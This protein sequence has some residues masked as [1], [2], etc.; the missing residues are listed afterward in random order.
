MVWTVHDEQAF[1]RKLVSMRRKVANE[2]WRQ[3]ET[4][5][6]SG[7]SLREIARN[8]NIPDGTVLSRA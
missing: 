3:I 7:I 5:Y 4:A 6:A 8:M 2:T 1:V